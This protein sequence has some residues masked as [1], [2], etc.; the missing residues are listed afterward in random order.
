MLWTYLSACTTDELFIL[1]VET[2]LDFS[3][4]PIVSL[5]LLLQLLQPFLHRLTLSIHVYTF[6]SD[7][8]TATTRLMTVAFCFLLSAFEA[9][10]FHSSVSRRTLWGHTRKATLELGVEGS[11]GAR[12]IAAVE[13][14]SIIL[15]EETGCCSGAS[16]GML[17]GDAACSIAWNLGC[18][19]R[20]RRQKSHYVQ[21]HR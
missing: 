19:A 9:G 1:A 21:V 5:S 15:G 2:R 20:V 3:E 11:R 12:C 8:G 4:K 16:G 7:T 17:E 10:S 13:W 14:G 6:H 18:G